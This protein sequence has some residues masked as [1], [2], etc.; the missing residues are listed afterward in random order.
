MKNDV[1]PFS[2]YYD[3]V[4]ATQNSQFGDFSGALMRNFTFGYQFGSPVYLCP[5]VPFNVQVSLRIYQH[6]V[7]SGIEQAW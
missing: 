4:R 2:Y 3:T 6:L 1:D 5:I 7:A